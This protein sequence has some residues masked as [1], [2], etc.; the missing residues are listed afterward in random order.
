MASVSLRKMTKT[1][2]GNTVVDAL[3]LEIED[4]EFFTLLGP[5]GCGKTTTLRCVAGLERPDGGAVHIGGDAVFD[6]ADGRNLQ[7]EKRGAGMVFQTYA[8]WPHM[9]V[10]ANVAYP[11]RRRGVNRSDSKERAERALAQVSLTGLGERSVAALSGGQQQRVALA[12]A[13]VA[14]PRLILFDEPLSNLDAKLRGEMRDQIGVLQKR[15]GT[16]AIYVTHD[17]TEALTLSDRIA[18]MDKGR[19]QQLG[20]PQE[21]YSRPNNAFVADFVGFE[22][23]LRGHIRNRLQ[24]GSGTIDVDGVGSIEVDDIPASSGGSSVLVAFRATD[25]SVVN[26]GPGQANAVEATVKK[27]MY[28]GEQIEVTLDCAGQLLKMRTSSGSVQ[29]IS[30]YSEGATIFIEV[31]RNAQ[32]LEDSHVQARVA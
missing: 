8:L 25:T 4:G 24:S 12:R 15:L 30:A 19:I 17:Q 1:Y 27:A 28:L 14:E 10:L 9:S 6:T 29:N 2:G 20:T 18:V 16:T 7:P 26:Q 11:L 13:L 31:P 3:D 5:S 23:M 32:V 21:I 22:N